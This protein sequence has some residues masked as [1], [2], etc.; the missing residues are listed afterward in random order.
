MPAASHVEKDGHVHA[1]PSGWCSGATRRSTRRATRARSCGSC[2]TCSSASARTT[3]AP[4]AE[5]DWPIRQPARG[6]T[7]STARQREPDVE[8]V[9]R[10]INGYDVATGEP[11]AGFAAARGRRLDRVRLLD[12]LRR[13]RRRR[14]PGPPA[15]PGRCRRRGRLGLARVGV[16]VAGQPAHALQPRL[17]PTPRASRGRSARSYVWWDEAQEKWTGYDVPDFPVD[18]PPGLPR[19]RTTREGMDAIAGDRPV[20]HDGRRPR[21]GCSRRPACST[22]RCRR[23]TSRSSRRSTT[24]L[25]PELAA[26]TRRRCAGR[27]RTTRYAAARRPALP[28]RGDDVPADRAPHGRRHV[29]LAAVAG[30]A[31]AGDVR[32]DRPGARRRARAS[33]T[34]AG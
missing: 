28:V 11:V 9:L 26:R 18:K 29:A 23:T 19:R 10:E 5:R 25:Y 6:T 17:A 22:A 30:R 12:L 27:G 4:T 20:H 34:A 33:R 32:R 16:G 15:R 14:Q 24:S 21:A 3:R 1:T 2:T 31:A 8:D 7:P 13:L